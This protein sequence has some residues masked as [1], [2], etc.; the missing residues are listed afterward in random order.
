[1]KRAISVHLIIVG[2]NLIDNEYSVGLKN[3]D[4]KVSTIQIELDNEADIIACNLA[5]EHIKAPLEWYEVRKQTFICLNNNL[6][7][8]YVATVPQNIKLIKEASWYSI[9]SL[10]D[11]KFVSEIEKDIILEGIRL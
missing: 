1:M 5:V 2:K 4:G 6:Y 9:R 7:L 10:N 8:I 11:A 3:I